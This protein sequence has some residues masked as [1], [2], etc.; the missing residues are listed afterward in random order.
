MNN[1]QKVFGIQTTVAFFKQ[2]TRISKPVQKHPKKPY[3]TGQC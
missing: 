1:R 2:F 3:R